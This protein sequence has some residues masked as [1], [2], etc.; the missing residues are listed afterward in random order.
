MLD[1]TSRDQGARRATWETPRGTVDLPAVLH[2]HTPRHPAPDT[3]RACIGPTPHETIPT[4]TYHGTRMD[5]HQ[6][7]DEDPFSIPRTLVYPATLDDALHDAADEQA[8]HGPV[9]IVHDPHNITPHDGLLITP[10][11]RRIA[12]DPWHLARF[13]T[14]ARKNAGPNAILYTPGI[15]RPD[16]MALA[17]MAGIDLFD[18]VTPLL[19]ALNQRYL[20]PEGPLP[21]QTL[22]D[23][24]CPCPA[25]H[26]THGPLPQDKLIHHNRTAATTE[27]QR[28][29]HAT[30]QGTLRELVEQRS[31]TAPEHVATYRRYDA[32]HAPFFEQRTPTARERGLPVLSDQTLQR[33]EIQRWLTRLRD[34]YTP[35]PSANVLIVLPCSA[36]KPYQQSPTHQRIRPS[37]ENPAHGRA[38]VASLTSPLGAVPEELELAYPA[39]HYDVPVTGDWSPQE[40]RIIQDAFR[41]LWKNGSYDHAILHLPPD[42]ATLLDGILDAERTVNPGERPTD[43]SATDRLQDAV[44]D[45]TRGLEPTP[46]DELFLDHMR[47]RIDWQFGPGV[48]Q[49]LAR[50]T[51][52]RGRYPYLKLMHGDTQLLM[53]KPERGA[54]TLT[55]DGGERLFEATDAYNIEIDDFH[56][57]G[58]VF[59]PGVKAASHEIRAEDEVLIHHEGELRAVGRAT[60]HG[61]EI[62]ALNQG[63]CAEVRHRV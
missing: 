11:A 30:Q 53:L 58:T 14:T 52:I 13:L 38:H 55:A 48:S 46:R 35:P 34:R 22:D 37:I 8:N 21:N 63:A 24:P 51:E 17:A 26:D 50:D 49:P 9:R 2:A 29:R 15:G 57:K 62:E 44:R 19:A 1:I 47:A 42:E 16:Q 7:D 10:T 60:S 43:S 4:V 33:P 32:D 31:R 28:I 54:L 59:A 36:T 27:A 56:P 40:Q 41:T 45:A 6:D 39:A 5:P 18:G 25:C 3:A 61:E 23:A 20:T 12:D